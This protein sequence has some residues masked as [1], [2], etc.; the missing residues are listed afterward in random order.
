LQQKT[1]TVDFLSHKRVT[2]RNYSDQ[3]LVEDNHVPIVSREVWDAV[4][5]EKEKRALAK[6]NVIGDRGKYTSKYP[7][8]GKIICG[9]CGA[10]FKRRQWNSKNTSKKNV[11]QCTTYINEGKDACHMKAIDEKVLEQAFVDWFNE[12]YKDRVKVVDTMK[13]NIEDVIKNL[14]IGID[15]EKLE[16]EIE[17]V[18][19]DI[20]QLVNFRMTGDIDIEVYQ[21]ENKRLNAVLNNL[22]SQRD[23]VSLDED[24]KNEMRRQIEE[25]ELVLGIR[26]GLLTEFDGELF[27][28]LVERIEIGEGGEIGFE[29]LEIIKHT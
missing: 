14:N 21:E 17:K 11:W 19:D 3:Y 29:L 25:I 28:A 9:D 8:S 15:A 16:D 7:F 20:K 23:V 22:R 24:R 18:K 2:N 12:L 13:K 10:K 1:V 5:K 6:N 26:D 4:Q 27:G